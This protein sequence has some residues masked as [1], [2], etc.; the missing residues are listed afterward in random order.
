MLL[1]CQPLSD[2]E[3]AKSGIH[4]SRTRRQRAKKSTSDGFSLTFPERLKPLAR[5]FIEQAKCHP[6][7]V[8]FTPTEL[9][10]TIENRLWS[11]A[12]GYPAGWGTGPLE[13]KTATPAQLEALA[14]ARAK[15]GTTEE[16]GFEDYINSRVS[17]QA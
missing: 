8:L 10:T 5:K 3:R 12:G 1:S 9:I 13:K 6:A 15:R 14:K 17:T 16:D 4:A 11:I 2:R 7:F